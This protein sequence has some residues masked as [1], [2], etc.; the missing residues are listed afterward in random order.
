ML[1]ITNN[2]YLKIIGYVILLFS[3]IMFIL[4]IVSTLIEIIYSAG[5]ILGSFIRSC[6]G[7]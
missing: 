1:S 4:P 6:S 2:K 7:C 3:I 5:T